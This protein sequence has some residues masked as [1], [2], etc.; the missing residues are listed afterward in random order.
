MD[1]KRA[2]AGF[3]SA[4]FLCAARGGDCEAG[5]TKEKLKKIKKVEKKAEKGR[6]GG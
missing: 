1:L 5:E 6:C 3:V 2:E 4:R